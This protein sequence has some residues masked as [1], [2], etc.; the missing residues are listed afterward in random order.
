MTIHTEKN[1]GAAQS[2]QELPLPPGGG[3]W[4]FDPDTWDWIPNN[5][6]PEA[7]DQPNQE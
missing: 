1:S 4:R 5:P 3:S 7:A 6:M 2:A